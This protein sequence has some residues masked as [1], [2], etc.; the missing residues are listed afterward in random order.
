MLY[1]SRQNLSQWIGASVVTIV[2]SLAIGL[3]QVPQ[4]KQISTKAKTASL[5]ELNKELQ[6]EKLRLNLLHKTPSFGFNNL[7]ANWAFL[8]F[9]TYLGDDSA[10]EQT[11]YSLSPEYFEIIVDRDPRFFKMYLFLSNT[12]SMY[13]GMPEESVALMEKGLKSLSPKAPP[14]SYY[15]WRYKGTDELLFLGDAQAARKSF[16]KA[17]EWASV[18]ADTD[19]QNVAAISRQTAQF[20]A[21]NPNSKYAQ[22]G[23]WSMVL[24]NAVDDRTRKIAISRIEGLGGKVVVTPEGEVRVQLPEKD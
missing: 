4:L 23:A 18:Y 5:E 13:A 2:C 9:L 10:R 1:K 19:S 17:A 7:F 14:R 22:V 8:G 11:G 15:V 3:L 24:Q 20:L 6:A 21:R 12:I 16:E